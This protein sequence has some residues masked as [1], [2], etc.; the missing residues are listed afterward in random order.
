MKLFLLDI[1]TDDSILFVCSSSFALFQAKMAAKSVEFDRHCT[2]FEVCNPHKAK[3]VLS[4]FIDLASALPCRIAVYTEG[5]FTVLSTL[6]PTILLGAYK[7]SDDLSS[8]AVEV[9]NTME[10][11]MMLAAGSDAL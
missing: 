9:E 7:F 2:V 6:K 3:D 5:E 8:S 10:S 1:F 4:A 11:I